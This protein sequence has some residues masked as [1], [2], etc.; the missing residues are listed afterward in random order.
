MVESGSSS[1]RALRTSI[2]ARLAED[3][4]ETREQLAATTEI[5]ALLAASSS[6]PEDVFTAIVERARGLCFADVAQ[7]HLVHGDAFALAMSAGLTPEYEAFS[8]NAPIQRDRTTL[9]GRVS[10]DRTTQQIADVLAD[11]EYDQPERQ[12]RAGFRSILGAPMLVDDEVVGVLSVW[13]ARVAPFDDR[14][15][16]L[17]TAFAAQG[18]L[19]IRNVQLLQSLET[20]SA[21]LGRRVDQLEALAEVGEAVSSSL[22]ADEVLTTIVTTAVELSGTDGGSLMEY[23][24]DSELFSVRT[25]FGTSPHVLDA[26]RGSRIHIRETLVGRACLA[27]TPIQVEDLAAVERDPHL[28]VLHAAGWR[29]VVA[30]PMVR[31]GRVVGALVVRRKRPGRF[32]EETCEILSAFASQSAIALTNARLY[33]QLERQSRELAEASRHKS[34]FLASMSHELRTPLNAVIGFSEVLLERMFGDLNARQEDY[35]RDILGSGRHLLDLLNDVLDLSKVEAGQMELSPTRF[36]AEAAVGYALSMVRERALAHRIA[37]DVEVSP[38][39]GQIRADELRFKQVLLNLL[40]NAVKFTPD[41]GRVGVTVRASGDEVEVTVTDT[42]VGIAP[43]D[44]ERI[45]D[46]FQQGGLVNRSIE[47]TGL[48]LTLTRRIVELHG[49]RVWLTSRLGHGSTFSFTIPQDPTLATE[50]AG[51]DASD[52]DAPAGLSSAPAGGR[53]SADNRPAVVIVEDD[54]N[55]AELLSLHLDAAGMRPVSVR[56]GEDGLATVRAL[57]PAAVILDIRLPGMDGWDVL[58]ALKGDPDTAAIPVVVVSVIHERG[59]GFALGASDYLV[60]PVAREGLLGALRRLVPLPAERAGRV[61]VCLDDDRSALELVRLTLEPA[62]WTVHMCTQ[63]AEAYAAIQSVHPSVVLVD[64][65]MP[66]IDGFA[67]IDTLRSDPQTASLPIVVLTAKSL[68]A[69]DRRLLEGR[70]AFVTSKNAMDLGLLA[71][72]LAQVPATAAMGETG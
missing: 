18:A 66:Q 17:L 24:E 53:G 34:E 46:S 45:F 5:L 12:Q 56:S 2:N 16:E 57:R 51:S 43:A 58:A 49:G 54:A 22:D 3:L 71:E 30:V 33:Q 69:Q 42:G 9:V 50:G 20:R 67:V 27:R 59:K 32:S 41:G 7:F 48:G 39:L 62:G 64:L 25:A 37:L 35:L 40:S 28:S 38:G 10:L 72:R 47:G 36:S 52:A 8:A 14:V 55:S 31:A 19:A 11:P 6:T 44:Q 63:A 26:L 13:R 61:A 60:K 29:S 65:L 23:D 15:C 4:E 1:G 70:I 68:T 21:E